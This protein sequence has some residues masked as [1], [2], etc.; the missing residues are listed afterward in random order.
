MASSL[1]KIT[2]LGD[3]VYSDFTAFETVPQMFDTL[4]DFVY[5]P[6]EENIKILG[7]WRKF[8]KVLN[9]YMTDDMGY[10]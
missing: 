8:I 4:I 10:F 7:K 5:G 2:S 9:K 3:L 6:C 1:I